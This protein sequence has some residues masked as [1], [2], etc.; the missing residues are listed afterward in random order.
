MW[1]LPENRFADGSKAIIFFFGLENVALLFIS[2]K[3]LQNQVFCLVF[4]SYHKITSKH[5]D[6][7]PDLEEFHGGADVLG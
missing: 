7:E 1:I 5:N 6:V 3:D 4:I 2:F